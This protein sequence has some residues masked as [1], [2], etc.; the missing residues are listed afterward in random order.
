MMY[1]HTL[2]GPEEQP[3]LCD[4]FYKDDIQLQIQVLPPHGPLT[5]KEWFPIVYLTVSAKSTRVSQ[6]L[7]TYMYVIC[8]PLNLCAFVD[9]FSFSGIFMGMFIIF[10]GL[11]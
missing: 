10:Y 7:A 11:C 9:Y 3:L 2:P 8:V 1:T 6:V 4:L 5:Q